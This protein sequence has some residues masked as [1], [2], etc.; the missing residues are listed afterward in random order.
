MWTEYESWLAQTGGKHLN[1]GLT[2]GF[3]TN[4]NAPAHDALRIHKFL[5]KK[6]ITQMGHPPYSPDLDPMIPGSFQN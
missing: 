6:S 2:S 4:D 3:S 5:A 1:S